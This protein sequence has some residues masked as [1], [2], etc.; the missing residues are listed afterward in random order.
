MRSDDAIVVLPQ[1]GS[2]AAVHIRPVSEHEDWYMNRLRAHFSRPTTWL[3]SL[4]ILLSVA[5]AWQQ[6][7]YLA[8]HAE[9]THSRGA[10]NSTLPS[11]LPDFRMGSESGAYDEVTSRPLLNPSRRPA[12]LQA[13]ASAPE[14]PKPQI[15]RGLY[16]MMGVL[17][18]GDKR[19]AQLRELAANRVHTVRVGELLQEFRVKKITPEM[20][21]LEF[22]GETD[23]VRLPSFTN[24]AR[25]RMLMPAPPPVVA[26]LPATTPPPPLSQPP[27]MPASAQAPQ[28]LAA[29]TSDTA[30]AT[31]GA[32]RP[33]PTVMDARQRA[34]FLARRE[35]ARRAWNDK[36]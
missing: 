14:P 13:V 28:A 11:V 34:E 6:Q 18:I 33:P 3:I 8:S 23:D 24:S 36:M 9:I 4:A 2:S 7:I 16:E 19:L 17:E 5:L 31:G 29:S 20:V 22:A 26:S 30:P 15:R 1:Q 27:M 10:S 32:E 35:E 12:P 25:A 21:S